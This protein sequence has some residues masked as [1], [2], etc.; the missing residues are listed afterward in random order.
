MPAN[1]PNN[2]ALNQVPKLKIPLIESVPNHT[3][4]ITDSPSAVPNAQNTGERSIAVAIKH[5]VGDVPNVV[6]SG[7]GKTAEKIVQLA[8]EAGVKVRQDGDLA[9]ILAA[10]EI[11]SP[12]PISSFE[13]VAE[14]LNY[15]YKLNATPPQFSR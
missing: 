11:D 4:S 5:D 8:Y 9:Q 7:Y 12:I 14:I 10:V 2:P 6:A 15:L 3:I 13:A 1:P